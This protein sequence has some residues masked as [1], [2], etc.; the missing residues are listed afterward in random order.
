MQL[1]RWLMALR[2]FDQRKILAAPKPVEAA[3]GILKEARGLM[4]TL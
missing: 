2:D 4:E 1:D 3:R